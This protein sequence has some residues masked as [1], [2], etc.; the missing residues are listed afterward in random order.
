VV[1]STNST[2]GQANAISP[3][4][5]NALWYARQCVDPLLLYFLFFVKTGSLLGEFEKAKTPSSKYEKF[6]V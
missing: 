6:V 2:V 3:R 5:S 1:L 4:C